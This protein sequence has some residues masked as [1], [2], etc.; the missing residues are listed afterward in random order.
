[1]QRHAAVRAQRHVVLR[2]LIIFR[3]I[4]VE[5]IFAIEL[6]DRRDIASEHQSRQH[7]H[8][9][10]F[11]IHHRQRAGQP[12]ANRTS[13]RVRLGAKFNR[14]SAKHFGSRL[15]LHVHFQSDR[16]D[17][18]HAQFLTQSPQ[19]SQRNLM[20][21]FTIQATVDNSLDPVLQVRFAEI[22]E[23]AQFRAA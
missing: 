4:R 12:E 14:R 11:L 6:A 21:R 13:V 8:A 2:N 18:V 19:R 5:I 23:K 1:M 17:V 22:N 16:R 20:W 10:R 9:Q 7:G 3:H 15:E